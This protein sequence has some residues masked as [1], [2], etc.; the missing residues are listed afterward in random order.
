MDWHLKTISRQSHASD[1]RFV[2]GDAV[3]SYLLEGEDGEISRADVLRDEG[4]RFSP[5]GKVLGWWE[6]VL[7]DYEDEAEAKRQALRT[8]EGFFLSLFETA[9][10]VA[11]A[12]GGDGEGNAAAPGAVDTAAVLKVLLAAALERKRILRPIDPPANDRPQRY[13]HPA[14]ERRF[15]IPAVELTPEAVLRVREQVGSLN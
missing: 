1:H 9:D 2:A 6:Q 5:K 14:S 10:E 13:F 7:R 8:T 3:I 15:E 12:G 4:E 11:G